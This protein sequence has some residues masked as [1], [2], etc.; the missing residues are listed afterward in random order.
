MEV[1]ISH[2]NY[3]FIYFLTVKACRFHSNLAKYAAWWG[4]NSLIL[5]QLRHGFEYVKM[6]TL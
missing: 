5:A 1:S 2:I 3:F 6:Y 4:K